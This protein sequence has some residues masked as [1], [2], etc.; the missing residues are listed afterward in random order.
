MFGDHVQQLA[1]KIRGG[2]VHLNELVQVDRVHILWHS[3][4]F[5]RMLK[6]K[7]G[8]FPVWEVSGNRENRV[9]SAWAPESGLPQIALVAQTH[10]QKS[11]DKAKLARVLKRAI[12]DQTGQSTNSFSQP[13]YFS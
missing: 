4:H 1:H 11:L 13:E 8:S 6:S 7:K 10:L 12:L 3:Y 2:Q 5:Q 9:S